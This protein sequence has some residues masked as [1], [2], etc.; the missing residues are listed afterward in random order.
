[1]Q[2]PS[3]IRLV[4]ATGRYAYK[5]LLAQMYLLQVS[6]RIVGAAE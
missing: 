5:Q 3:R 1:M 2:W 6:N 4:V